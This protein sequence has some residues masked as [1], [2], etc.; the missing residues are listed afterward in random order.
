M[1]QNHLQSVRL[2][3][4]ELIDSTEK[5]LS[6]VHRLDTDLIS[7]ATEADPLEWL[8]FTIV[9]DRLA[10]SATMLHDNLSRLRKEE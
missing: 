6:V 2:E 3:I 5:L 1:E 9:L 4:V 10:V 7:Q 8:D